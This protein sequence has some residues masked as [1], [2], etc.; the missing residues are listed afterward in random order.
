MGGGE[1]MEKLF[2]L[3]FNANSE[4]SVG[5]DGYLVRIIYIVFEVL[6]NSGIKIGSYYLRCWEPLFYIMELWLL[7]AYGKVP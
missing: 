2:V 7:G 5:Y 4:L 3:N 1:K 6:M